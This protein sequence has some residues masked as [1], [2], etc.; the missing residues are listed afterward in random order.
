MNFPISIK[1]GKL[2]P[3]KQSSRIVCLIMCSSGVPSPLIGI[4]HIALWVQPV[5]STNSRRSS[6]LVETTSTRR[7]TST[8]RHY[9]H[10]PTPLTSFSGNQVHSTFLT[11]FPV[12]HIFVITFSSY[13]YVSFFFLSYLPIFTIQHIAVRSHGLPNV[14]THRKGLYINLAFS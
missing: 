2:K 9:I 6:V 13:F 5:P 3:V 12:F 14:C 10:L 1:E 4:A 8:N 11:D 7:S